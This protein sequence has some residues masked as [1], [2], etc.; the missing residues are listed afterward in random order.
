[1][2]LDDVQ[3]FSFQPVGVELLVEL[4]PPLPRHDVH[5]DE[6][7]LCDSDGE[8]QANSQVDWMVYEESQQTHVFPFGSLIIFH[9]KYAEKKKEGLLN[10]LEG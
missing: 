10:L 9:V 1:M 5:D 3:I 6:R 2:V 7:Q 4:L 8:D